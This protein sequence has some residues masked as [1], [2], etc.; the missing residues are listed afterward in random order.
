[1]TKKIFK[2]VDRRNCTGSAKRELRKILHGIESGEIVSVATVFVR[3]NGTLKAF[4]DCECPIKAL[5]SVELL[6]DYIRTKK[7]EQV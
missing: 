4:F 3:R 5:G 6:K 1:M 2:L 7:F